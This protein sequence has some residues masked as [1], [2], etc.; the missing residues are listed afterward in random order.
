ME[1]LDNFFTHN[2][3]RIVVALEIDALIV[4]ESHLY[5]LWI[6]KNFNIQFQ[7]TTEMRSIRA[8]ILIAFLIWEFRFHQ[9]ICTDTIKASISK[10]TTIR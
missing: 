2:I 10:A 4:N 7:I 6:C 3:Y 5:L 1:Q 8:D 9:P